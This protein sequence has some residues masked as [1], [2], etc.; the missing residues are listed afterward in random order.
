M[1]AFSLLLWRVDIGG[2]RLHS[3]TV[4]GRNKQ[5]AGRTDDLT[6]KKSQGAGGIESSRRMQARSGRCCTSSSPLPFPA[7]TSAPQSAPCGPSQ[8]LS[9]CFLLS[10]ACFISAPLDPVPHQY[11]TLSECHNNIEKKKTPQKK[12][13]TS[14]DPAS[15]SHHPELTSHTAFP[16][17]LGKDPPQN[18]SK[19]RRGIPQPPPPLSNHSRL[20]LA[21]PVQPSAKHLSHPHP[22]RILNQKSHGR[23]PAMCTTTASSTHSKSPRCQKPRPQRKNEWI[24]QNPTRRLTSRQPPFP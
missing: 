4:N 17:R 5:L 22:P 18:A 23:S 2:S 8:A 13:R 11:S 14:N 7:L 24:P 19:R 12:D 6:N 16:E 3:S 21:F 9:P 1:G 20:H 15:N 10:S